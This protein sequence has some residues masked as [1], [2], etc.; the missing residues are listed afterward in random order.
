MAT[1]TRTKPW[2]PVDASIAYWKSCSRLWDVWWTRMGGEAAVA[3]ARR[4]RF[5]ALVRFARLRSPLYAD[6]YRGL[7]DRDLDPHEL[8]I[9]TKPQLMARFDE[10]V[11]D[12]EVTLDGVT[13]F[14]A[15]RAH[16][17]ERYLGRYVV[18]KSSGSTSE[19]GIYVQDEDALATFDALMVAHLDPVQFATRNAFDA[20]ARGGRA[21]LVVATGDHFA[22]IASWQRVCQGSPWLA[23]RGFSIM[24]PLPELVAQLNAYQPVFLASYPTMLMM[25]AEE[26]EAGRLRVD[27][28]RLWAGG[29]RLAPD[30]AAA[31]ERAFDCPLTNEYGA[32]ECMSI[33]YGCREGALHVNADWVLLE[34]VDRDYRPTP[35]GEV[36][37]TVLLSNLANRVQPI[38]RYDLGDRVIARREPCPC[39]NRLPAIEVEGRRDDVVALRAPDGALVRLLPLALTTVVEQAARIA[40]FQIAQTGE[41]RLL[42]RLPLSGER[43]RKAAW[44]AAAG[45]L[46]AY[47]AAQGLP[48]VAVELD[49]LGPVTDR[50]SGKLREVV[51]AME[52][53]VPRRGGAS[54]KHLHQKE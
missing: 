18:W 31:I 14:V 10:W 42:L 9:A 16:I 48:N 44:H 54:G 43:A 47:L 1:T 27:P 33:A 11:T 17:G 22:S 50:R 7:P 8:P 38:L 26:R 35:P 25:L 41:D 36:S 34:P 49:M 12:P 45:G 29:E 24:L 52:G 6:T 15:D 21:A 23:A 53:A 3:A 5:A 28:I 2:E 20:I 4:R 40:R 13:A 32:S 51:V 39:G 19:P 30:A 37:H 46:L